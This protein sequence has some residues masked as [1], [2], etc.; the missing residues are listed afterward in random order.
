MAGVSVIP[1]EFDASRA[2]VGPRWGREISGP[3]VIESS[4]E[5]VHVGGEQVGVA[6]HG[7]RDG[8]VAVR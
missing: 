1:A 2:F 8:G 5:G 7:H 6:V 3:G 4:D